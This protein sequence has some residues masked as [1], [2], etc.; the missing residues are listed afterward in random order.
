MREQPADVG[1]DEVLRYRKGKVPETGP[2]NRKAI[3]A[4]KISLPPWLTRDA[5]T[6][7]STLR[8]ITPSGAINEEAARPFAVAGIKAALLRGSLTHR[9]MQSLPD[10]PTE[11][12]AKTAQDYL[13]RRGGELTA[14]VRKAISD[15]VMGVL[16]HQHFRELFGPNSRAEVP[17]IGRVM[18]GGE[19]VRVSGQVDRLAVTPGA[20]LIG[21]F[22][23]NRPAPRRIEDVPEGYI[24]QLA[25]YRAVLAKIY[26]DR[27]ICAAL[28]WTE[29]PDLM[30][31]SEVTLDNAL[32]RV[33]SV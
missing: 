26:S 5:P 2:A 17:I 33:T 20:V 14:D 3:P 11:R 7:K 32:A 25:R 22:K 30:E 10:I 8:S 19:L 4:A 12:R 29:V 21:D 18:A 15:E 16:D 13:A 1:S 23:T 24:M 31:L 9:L 6:D 27:P 28:I